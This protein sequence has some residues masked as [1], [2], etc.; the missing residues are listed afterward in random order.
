MRRGLARL[1]A[2][3][4]KELAF[5]TR[6][7]EREMCPALDS[8]GRCEAYGF[9]PLICRSYGVPLR[10]K[11]EVNL[12]SPP[13]LEICDKN[14]AGVSLKTLPSDDILDQTDLDSAVAEIN[15]DYCERE[16]QSAEERVPIAQILAS[17][18]DLESSFLD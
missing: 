18:S 17:D 16:G 4:R 13:Q 11:R 7:P 6:D 9:R 14:F 10:R 15:A 12:I 5:R 3:K 8:E 2:A 1:A